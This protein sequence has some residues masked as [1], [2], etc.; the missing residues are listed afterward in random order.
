VVDE[1]TRLGG[2]VTRDPAT[3]LLTVNDEFTVSLVIAR[4]QQTFAG[5]YR[6]NIRLDRLLQPD[7][8]VAVRM[9]SANESPLDYYLL[10]AFDMQ[11]HKLRLAEYNRFSVDAYRFDT[12]DFLHQLARRVNIEAA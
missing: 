4:C 11:L 7:I 6:W 10:P 9:D 5:A 3:D 12:L 8:T 1:M 2:G